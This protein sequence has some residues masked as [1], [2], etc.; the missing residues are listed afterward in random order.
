VLLKRKYD[1][2]L[3]NLSCVYMKRKILLKCI[4]IRLDTNL[5]ISK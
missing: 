5:K 2:L 3:D 4:K 1:N